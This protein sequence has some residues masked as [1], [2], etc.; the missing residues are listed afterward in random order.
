MTDKSPLYT[1]EKRVTKTLVTLTLYANL[2]Q[3]LGWYMNDHGIVQ[4][5]L[6]YSFSSVDNGESVK[7]YLNGGASVMINVATNRHLGRLTLMTGFPL[8]NDGFVA[9]KRARIYDGTSY[10]LNPFDVSV[11]EKVA[12]CLSV[13]P[14]NAGQL[15]VYVCVH[16][17]KDTT[18]SNNN[19]SPTRTKAC[20]TVAADD[21]QRARLHHQLGGHQE[22]L[23]HPAQYFCDLEYS[24]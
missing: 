14:G 6:L 22:G 17:K 5:K 19:T 12:T 21:Q 9:L 18:K 13:L 20:Y 2:N 4:D 23:L 16:G 3:M 24:S 10:K 8:N 7:N 15:P 1:L 11:E